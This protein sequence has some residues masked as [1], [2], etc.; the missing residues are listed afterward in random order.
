M[1][2]CRR[3]SS[4]RPHLHDRAPFVGRRILELV[5]AVGA[6]HRAPVRAPMD[7]YSEMFEGDSEI[8]KIFIERDICG[9]TGHSRRGTMPDSISFLFI[10]IY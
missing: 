10:D 6:C 2:R 8:L 4:A 1:R 3:F 9:G 5:T 7:A